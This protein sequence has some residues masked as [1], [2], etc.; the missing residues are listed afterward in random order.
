MD[1]RTTELTSIEE[2]LARLE[3]QQREMAAHLL[4]VETMCADMLTVATG[5]VDLLSAI[6]EKDGSR[7][8]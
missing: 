4:R 5:L 6:L 2:A 3:L 8:D 7:A 1:K